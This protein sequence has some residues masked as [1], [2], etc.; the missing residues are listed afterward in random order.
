MS[1][2]NFQVKKNK[3][4]EI[5]VT[6]KSLSLK[7]ENTYVQYNTENNIIMIYYFEIINKN[8][9]RTTKSIQATTYYLFHKS[10]LSKVITSFEPVQEKEK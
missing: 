6:Y 5:N 10:Y 3:R 2:H 9:T 8:K 1:P 7:L 4:N